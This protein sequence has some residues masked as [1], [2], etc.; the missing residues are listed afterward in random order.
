MNTSTFT[1]VLQSRLESHAKV[2]LEPC[3]YI[4]P[5]VRLVNLKSGGNR[6][7]ERGTEQRSSPLSESEAQ[8][9]TE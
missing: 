3:V 2:N 9:D 7:S 1:M 6:T 4:A 5:G 8:S